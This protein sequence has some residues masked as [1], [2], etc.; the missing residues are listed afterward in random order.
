MLVVGRMAYYKLTFT[1]GHEWV[2]ANID[3]Q[4][5]MIGSKLH[6]VI[7]STISK[8][9]TNLRG[10]ISA[11]CSNM[12]SKPRWLPLESNPEVMNK[13]VHDLGMSSKW[14]F[15]DVFG[16]DP[17]LLGMVPSPVAAILL[18]F[19]INE[20][21]ETFKQKEQ[22]KIEK[23]G[24]KVSGDVYFMKQTIGN[25]CG[26][27]GLLHAVFNNTDQIAVDTKLKKFLDETKDMTPAEK[28]EHL[29][30]DESIS[31]A[32]ESSAQQGQTDAPSRDEE[33]N[34]HFIAFVHKDGDLYELDGR[35]PFPINHGKSSKET[36][37]QD[38]AKVCKEFMDRDPSELHFTV[39]ALAA[40]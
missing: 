22:E 18:L 25:A 11:H 2:Y 14:Q 26:T 23:G 13:F 21:Y 28:A 24:Q 4:R 1:K 29:A 34:L 10:R 12:A 31:A 5:D 39:V 30:N 20:K 35:K 7:L 37:L 15:C 17:G 19:P 38:A 9:S 33:V 6:D 8:N 40:A 27:I 3:S 36:I 32:H 16:L